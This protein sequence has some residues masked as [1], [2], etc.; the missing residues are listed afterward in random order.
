MA[1]M[2]GEVVSAQL[3]SEQ[4]LQQQK[5]QQQ[6][7]Q[8]CILD[9]VMELYRRGEFGGS[10][11][12]S[13][14]ECGSECGSA[15][16]QGVPSASPQS[17]PRA[18]RATHT[19]SDVEVVDYPRFQSE[20][21]IVR[22]LGRGA[23]G[24]VWH[25]RRLS[26][27][28]EFA[29]KAVR[30][31][32]GGH[33][34]P[35][36]EQQVLREAQMLAMMNHPNI[37]HFHQAWI[38]TLKPGRSGSF[39]TSTAT[40]TDGS[41]AALGGG[42]AVSFGGASRES[43]SSV[44]GGSPALVSAPPPSPAF[45]ARLPLLDSGSDDDSCFSYDGGLDGTC[46]GDVVVFEFDSDDEERSANPAPVPP[47]PQSSPVPAAATPLGDAPALPT[48]P[49]MPLLSPSS[50]GQASFA[51]YPG[52]ACF[53]RQ[54][55]SGAA[56]V[57]EEDSMPENT[58]TLYMQVELCRE[59]TLQGWI[60]KRN[61]Q[62]TANSSTEASHSAHASWAKPALS[63]FINCVRALKHIHG[64]NCVHRDVKPANIFFGRGD[65]PGAVRLGDLGLAKVLSEPLEGDREGAAPSPQL[66]P[67]P[68]AANPVEPWTPAGRPR[69][70]GRGG[71]SGV[72]TPSY[73]SP[74]QLSGKLVDTST[75]VYALGL[76]LAELLCPVST[77]ME[78]AAVLRGLRNQR[79]LPETADVFPELA[80]LAVQM[81]D[82]E[83]GA[84]PEARYI[85]KTARQVLRRL[86]RQPMEASGAA[87]SARP[88]P[89]IKGAASWHGHHHA[90]HRA[91]NPPA[92]GP[93]HSKRRSAEQ[94]QP[95][96]RRSGAAGAKQHLQHQLQHQRS[97][98]CGHRLPPTRGCGRGPSSLS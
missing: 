84:R 81:T 34:R 65:G 91:P 77:Q 93:R 88:P 23:F 54:R 50:A 57:G 89:P 44:A 92:T 32:A 56:S 38:E 7:Q 27:D 98:S 82:P 43:A 74:E 17:T 63:I 94:H 36:V 45:H 4:E 8:R 26:D 41:V 12:E 67:T 79:L 14:S 31:R 71:S 66:P 96:S 40:P 46:A 33:G 52:G 24:E 73:A 76:V 69:G 80:R 5:Q 72:G 18:H 19:P 2:N 70:S 16:D 28:R 51:P 86:R 20:Y 6:E 35:E 58:T 90:H 13:G 37:L 21:E 47:A 29:V 97:H 55:S 59:E 78:R 25:C 68:A 10:D 15:D 95:L 62:A 64:R 39:C 9:H 61:E 49:P 3:R 30:Y 60:Q 22:K 75:D 1:D 83:P 53:R 85:L 87:A 48:M 11:S 42:G